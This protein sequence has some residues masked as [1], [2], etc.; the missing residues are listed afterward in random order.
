VAARACDLAPELPLHFIWLGKEIERAV[1]DEA[2]QRMAAAGHAGR[3]DLRG[4]TPD[5][6][7]YYA[8]ADLL[9]LTSRLDAC[10]LVNAEAMAFGLPVLFFA[11]CSGAGELHPPGVD[12]AVPALDCAAMARRAVALLRDDAGRRR[13]GA[14][15]RAHAGETLVWFALRG[16]L[17]AVLD[18]R[19]RVPMQAIA[20]TASAAIAAADDRG[21]R[22]ARRAAAG[23]PP[24]RR[25]PMRAAAHRRR[26][27][28]SSSSSLTSRSAAAQLN[29]IRLA[30]ALT[31]THRVF[32]L[33]ARPTLYDETVARSISPDVVA[34]EGTLR[35]APWYDEHAPAADGANQGGPNHLDER[36]PPPARGRRADAP[37][38]H[39]D[40]AVAGLVERPLRARPAALRRLQPG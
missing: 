33:N 9:L 32:V 34:L 15:L 35:P 7:L 22:P 30:N 28:P 14:Q 3:L 31:A 17:G 36:R 21:R 5:P 2:R 38:R 18:V 8:A 1:R 40:G 26:R 37:P 13:L 16:L 10:P 11:G 6:Q 23:G 29:A 20:R 24:A 12:L 19:E 39:R 4:Q 25:R 27:S